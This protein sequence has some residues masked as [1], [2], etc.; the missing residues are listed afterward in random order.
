VTNVKNTIQINSQN[1]KV[2]DPRLLAQQLTMVAPL[3]QITKVN[4]NIKLHAVSKDTLV[5]VQKHIVQNRQI[6]QERKKL[7]VQAAQ[8]HAKAEK[9]GQPLPPVK[10][11]LPKVAAAVKPA[12]EVKGLQKPPLPAAPKPVAVKPPEHNEIKPPRLDPKPI[13][14]H[15]K[16]EKVQP[17]EEKKPPV[18][19]PKEEK[20]PPV[21]NPKEEKKPPVINPKEEKKP[22]ATPKDKKDHKDQKPPETLAYQ[23]ESPWWLQVYAA[24]FRDSPRSE[25]A[26]LE[27][28]RNR[29]PPG[30]T[31]SRGLM[32]SQGTR[33]G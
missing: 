23:T 29:T 16:D 9:A 19:N 12:P 32:L 18:I 8:I 4:T 28:S 27:R 3:A 15:P 22:P 10:L 11:A 1:Y 17:K 5:S 31:A 33:C 20:K 25:P 14:I 30:G 7:D 13:V 24:A 2:G 6:A 26:Y 21:I